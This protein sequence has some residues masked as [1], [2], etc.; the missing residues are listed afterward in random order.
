MQ[1]VTWRDEEGYLHRSIL[2]DGADIHLAHQG[3]P[4]DPPDLGVLDFDEI[5]KQLHNRLV[6]ERLFDYADLQG[7]NKLTAIVRSVVQRAISD[8]YKLEYQHKQEDN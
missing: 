6:E 5:R 8:L 2:P 3:I 1:I 7:N 4:A